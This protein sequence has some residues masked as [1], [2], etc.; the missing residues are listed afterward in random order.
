MGINR[1]IVKGNF[2]VKGSKVSL[3]IYANSITENVGILPNVLYNN[4]IEFDRINKTNRRCTYVYGRTSS[5]DNGN[6]QNKR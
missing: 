5:G 1:Y 2:V 6:N 3:S 4:N